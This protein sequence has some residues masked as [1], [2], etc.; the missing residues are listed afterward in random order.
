MPPTVL[1]GVISGPRNADAR[2]MLRRFY[3]DTM[4]PTASVEVEM[5]IGDEFYQH[6]PRPALLDAIETE[7]RVH[8]DVRLV[9]AR[10]QLPHVGKA[11]EKSAAW[12]A[13]AP[14]RRDAAFYCKTD[15]DTLIHAAHLEA[16]LRMLDPDERVLLSYVRW[17]G[18]MPRR[19]RACGG[20]WGGPLEAW[21]QVR[22]Q[23]PPYTEGPFPQ[24]TGQLTCLSRTLARALARS[25]DF[26]TFREV[27]Y[28]RNTFGTPCH[29]AP[30]C[31]NA[32]DATRMWHHEDAG[33]S[34]NVWKTATT[35]SRVPLRLVH[36]PER[37]WLWPWPHPKLAEA[38]A[39]A[40]F[41]HKVKPRLEARVRTWWTLDVPLAAARINCAQKCAA[42]GWTHTR[43]EVPPARFAPWTGTTTAVQA[44]DALNVSCCFVEAIEG[45]RAR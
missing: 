2:A 7:A 21:S 25:A 20:G 14:L 5:V 32:S 31:A 26:R 41:V 38:A 23:C 12:W 36:L 39:R 8:K 16:L 37:G 4:P 17:R 28:A 45:P 40:V 1:I 11:A 27:A 30:E 15:D 29:T 35:D 43:L 24:G 9:R 42:W 10:E 13:D 3:A 44:P 6:R 19:F 34:Y 33:V 22:D 18:W